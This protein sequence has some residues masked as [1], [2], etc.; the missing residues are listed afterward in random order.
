MNI[1]YSYP[2]WDGKQIIGHRNFQF[3]L[4]GKAVVIPTVSELKRIYNK[5]YE[6]IIFPISYLSED[7]G[8]TIKM[9]RV[10]DVRRKSQR[11]IKILLGDK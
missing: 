9:T 4:M 2:V 6:E 8:I 1:G 3:R 10:I 7:D 5:R 11:Q